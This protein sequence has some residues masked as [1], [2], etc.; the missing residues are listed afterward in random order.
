M[1]PCD[2]EVIG[3]DDCEAL[4]SLDDEIR[5][6][7][8]QRAVT[9]IW[10]W[11]NRRFGACPVSYRPCGLRCTGQCGGRCSYRSPSEVVLPGPIVEPLEIL[12]NGV[13]LDIGASVVV[14]D[15]NCVTRIGGG[16]FPTRQ[17]LGLPPTEDGTWQI[18]Y[19]KGEAIPPGGQLIAGILA[20]EYAKGLCG[21]DS[22]RLPRRVSSITRQGITLAMLD[23]FDQLGVGYTGIWE[24]DDWIT[25][26]TTNLRVGPW[27]A[28][29]VSSPDIV[30]HRRLTWP[31]P[32]Y[33]APVP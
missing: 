3:C 20:C 23:N 5:L 33:V 9:R 10:E 26:Y 14:Y 7:V 2:W 13:Q 28:S 6:M 16:R 12:I 22:C 1:Q 31:E 25:T 18:T 17:N 8:E 30:T 27:Q 29:A 4:T 15:Y 32:T 21:D 11:T 19:L 24:I